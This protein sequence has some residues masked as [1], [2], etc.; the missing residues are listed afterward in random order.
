MVKS[1]S[2]E[3][4]CMFADGIISE[5]NHFAIRWSFLVRVAFD[6]YPVSAEHFAGGFD[7]DVH[8]QMMPIH[9]A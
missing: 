4:P 3:N 7:R 5:L 6:E 9:G 2:I 1:P 8:L